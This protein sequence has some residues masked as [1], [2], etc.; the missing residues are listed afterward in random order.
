MVTVEQ[1][2]EVARDPLLRLV[3]DRKDRTGSLMA[4]YDDVGGCL[5]RSPSWVRKVIG[6]AADVSVGLHDWLNINTLC[7]RLDAASARLEAA[8][9]AREEARRAVREAAAVAGPLRSGRDSGP[10]VAPACVMPGTLAELPR[11]PG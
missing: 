5:G 10:A 11:A 9:A 8:T 3:L 1:A 6:R 7:A 2:N 4:A